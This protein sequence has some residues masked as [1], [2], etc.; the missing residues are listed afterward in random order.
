[1]LNDYRSLAK[2]GR[3]LGPAILPFPE[4]RDA[5]TCQPVYRVERSF[6][7]D[8]ADWPGY[9]HRRTIG[10]R[11]GNQSESL[12]DRQ[13]AGARTWELVPVADREGNDDD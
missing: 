2:S 10:Q 8:R 6:A 12:L 4:S 3:Q 9:E 13:H 11:G 5:A 1:M 7:F